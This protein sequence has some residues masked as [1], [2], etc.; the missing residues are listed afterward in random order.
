MLD[1]VV[2]GGPV[3][4]PLIFCSILAVAV[5]LERLWYM[6]SSGTDTEEFMDEVRAA[7]SNRRFYEAEEMA[8]R[9]K[10][11]V[12]AVVAA[13]ISQYERGKEEIRRR[14]EEAG[15]DEI[16][17]M[18]RG[19]VVLDAVVTIAPLLGLLGTVTGIIKSFRIL[20][21]MQGLAEPSMLSSG[22][23]EALIATATGLIIAIPVMA[24]YH[25]LSSQVEKRVAEMNKTSGELL[26]ILG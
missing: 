5:G 15:R 18:Q 10:G 12:P 7:L 6:Y 9:E 4:I 17:K 11:P 20:S 13:G 2:K 22:I 1:I 3:M 14:M 16:Y 21:A 19:L 23:A 25:Y 8:R 24:L 26:E